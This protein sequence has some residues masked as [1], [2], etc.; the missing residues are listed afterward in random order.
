[1]LDDIK[2]IDI[3]LLD[4]FL[5]ERIQ[6]NDTILDAGCGSGRNI[7]WLIK[8]N[9][10]VQGYDPNQFQIEQLKRLYPESKF[11]CS[12]IEET[13]F[14]EQQFEFI[15]CNAVL[16]FALDHSHF[17]E[18]FEAL[19]NSLKPKGVLFVRMTSNIGLESKINIE[20]NGRCRLPDISDRYVITRKQISDLCAYHSLELIE[21]VKSVLVEDL[22]SMAT[23]V[24]K[25][26]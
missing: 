19:V 7:H 2:G 1:M 8:N 10:S 11:E 23:I 22:R 9:Y 17:H 25:K 15:I 6:K 20:D 5:K 21:P 14:N 18:Q 4:Q 26:A 12:S 13:P 16:H 24:L 3:Y